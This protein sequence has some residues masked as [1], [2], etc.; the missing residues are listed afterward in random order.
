M[1]AGKIPKIKMMLSQ[2][3]VAA[4]ELARSGLVLD[5]TEDGAKRISWQIE[6]GVC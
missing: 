5:R 6:C 2:K 4:V 1:E 3:R